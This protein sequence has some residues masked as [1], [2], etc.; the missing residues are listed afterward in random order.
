M[1]GTWLKPDLGETLS[2]DP[3]GH[4]SSDTGHT[5]FRGNPWK[6]WDADGRLGADTYEE[7]TSVGTPFGTI[8]HHSYG[9]SMWSGGILFLDLYDMGPAATRE[10]PLHDALNGFFERGGDL[11]GCYRFN[12]R[13][14]I[15]RTGVIAGWGGLPDW[16][17][18]LRPDC[19]SAVIAL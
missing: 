12:W 5:P 11:A 18:I 6:I 14:K 4:A 15:C 3:Y 19:R 17:L 9:R 16:H 2:F 8:T 1:G 13:H 7:E 10:D